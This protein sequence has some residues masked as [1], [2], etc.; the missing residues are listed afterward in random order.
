MY[1]P[2]D[3]PTVYFDVDST[4]VFTAFEAPESMIGARTI[5]INDRAWIVHELHVAYIRDFHARG[6]NVIVWS[7]GGSEWAKR[8]VEALNL[9]MYVHACLAKPTWYFDDKLAEEW[10]MP[11]QRS[12]VSPIK[13]II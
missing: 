8:V 4:L 3:K 2:T 6:H 12:Y 1:T 7:Q 9:D 11:H 13:G 10:L 5:Y